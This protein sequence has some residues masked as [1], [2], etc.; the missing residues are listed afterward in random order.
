MHPSTAS[1]MLYSRP[2]Q[3][4]GTLGYTKTNLAKQSKEEVNRSRYYIMQS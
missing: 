2:C 3:Q 4:P 1:T